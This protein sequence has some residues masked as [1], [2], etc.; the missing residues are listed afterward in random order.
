[1]AEISELWNEGVTASDYGAERATYH[2]AVFEQYKLCV[3]MADRVSSRRN[4]A[5]TFF[6]TLHS[7]LVAFL[8]AW[9]SQAHHGRLSVLLLLAGLLVLLALCTAWWFTLRSYRQLNEGKFRVI[10]A[11][12]ERLPARAFQRAEWE[13]LGRGLDWHV[14]LPLTQVER[15]IPVIFAS[16]YFL[17]FIGLAV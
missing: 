1:M 2:E 15:W 9:L 13:A 14:Y 17:G 6:L 3:E 8:G 10:G 16:T 4:L 11:L 7:G 5:N 12:E